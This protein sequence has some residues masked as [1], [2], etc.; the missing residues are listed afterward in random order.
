MTNPY[1]YHLYLDKLLA[2]FQQTIYL[3]SNYYSIEIFESSM[4]DEIANADRYDKQGYEI[5]RQV[6]NRGETYRGWG[7]LLYSNPEI[8][9]TRNANSSLFDFSLGMTVEYSQKDDVMTKINQLIE[10]NKYGTSVLALTLNEVEHKTKVSLNF[11]A[12]RIIGHS[13]RTGE[14]NQ[15]YEVFA[16]VLDGVC[17]MSDNSVFY[18]EVGIELQMAKDGGGTE[19]VDV[20]AL[21]YE[22]DYMVK[23]GEGIQYN[24]GSSD[25][26]SFMEDVNYPAFANVLDFSILVENGR[27][28]NYFM[29]TYLNQSA[30]PLKRESI[31]VNFSTV[32]GLTDFTWN[33]QIISCKLKMNGQNQLLLGISAL[34]MPTA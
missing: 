18:D 14:N 1:P 17:F 30:N 10:D 2:F 7:L 15:T 19:Y 27:T 3:D 9:G 16:I 34:R 31:R 33:C 11:N 12:P 8:Q 23:S 32:S 25:V 4:A 26:D 21:D 24:Y 22:M 28:S 13:F 6:N 20:G 5:L 29:T